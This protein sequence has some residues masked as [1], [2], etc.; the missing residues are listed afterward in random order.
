MSISLS[1]S[2]S[3]A[4]ANVDELKEWVADE[5]DRDLSE[6]T[7]KLDKWIMLAE[8]R[9]NREIRCPDMETS[10]TWAVSSENTSLPSDYLSMRA[11][12]EEGSP[13]LPLRATSPSSIRQEYNGTAGTPEAYILVSGGLRLI[14]PPDAQYLL[15]MDYYAR[16]EGLSVASPSNWLLE[17]HPDAYVTGVLFHYYRWSKDR[18]SAVDANTLCAGIISDINQSA[19]KDRYGAGPLARS[20][21]GQTRG[22]RC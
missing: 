5:V 10:V 16:I 4:I 6:I 20:T 22:G 12:Y 1:V 14:P 8:A 19:K 21:I 18:D 9:F 17:K 13:D 2:Q 15:T 3:L 11:I 7:D